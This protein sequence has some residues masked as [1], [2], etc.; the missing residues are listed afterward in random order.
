MTSPRDYKLTVMLSRTEL[1]TLVT[2]A[3]DAGL[4]MSDVIRQ[5]VRKAKEEK[6]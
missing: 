4:S 6:R 3:A 5:L 1:Q 2:L